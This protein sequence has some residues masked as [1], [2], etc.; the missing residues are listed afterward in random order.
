MRFLNRKTNIDFMGKRKI[1]FVVSAV[2]IVLSIALGG[3]G[4]KSVHPRGIVV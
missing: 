2:L 3:S 4:G 1:A